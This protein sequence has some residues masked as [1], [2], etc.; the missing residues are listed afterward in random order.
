[1][2]VKGLMKPPLTKPFISS[3]EEEAVMRVLRSGWLMQ[4]PEVERFEK[5][6]AF[7]VGVGNAVA[8]SSGT[9]ALHLALMALGLEKGQEVI[10]PSF[11]FVA[12]AHAVL[13][14]GAR[15]VFVDI[16]PHSLNMDPRKVEEAMG[17][18][19]VGILVVHQFGLPAE[20]DELLA[21]AKSR[22]LWLVED[23]ACALGSEYRERK[24]G[25][26][27]LMTCFS[28]HPR[29]IITTG[30]GGMVCTDD[31]ALTDKLKA[32]RSHGLAPSS[33]SRQ[34][35]LLGYNYRMTDLQAAIG[36]E[37]LAKIETILEMRR[38]IAKQYTEVLDGIDGIELPK[39]PPHCRSNYQSY[40]L[41]VREKSPMEPGEVREALRQ[42]GIEV[43]LMPLPIHLQPLYRELS[44]DL[45]LPFTERA[46]QR[47][48]L[49]P[50]YPSLSH[51][52]QDYVI[53]SLLPFLSKR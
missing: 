36:L 22:C 35:D 24:I 50:L 27:G 31:S 1:M 13:Y 28:F 37:Q 16:D 47:G 45:R 2:R 17:E 4:G 49:L 43:G 40:P 11:S 32:L 34:Y 8:T 29:K 52:E 48:M 25:S 30:E 9:S 53:D 5:E 39:G 20:L 46:F 38:V 42:R 19:T 44:A 10:V 26:H 12:S 33:L 18:R 15:P 21:L 51:E 7:Y 3:E 6:V 14:C 41:V 23:A